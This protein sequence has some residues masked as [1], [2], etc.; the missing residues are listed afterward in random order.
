VDLF[1]GVEDFAFSKCVAFIGFGHAE[2]GPTLGDID[3]N[4]FLGSF[5]RAEFGGPIQE[6]EGAFFGGKVEVAKDH[7]LARDDDCFAITWGEDVVG[8]KHELDGF[9]L[10]CFAKWDVDRHL[11]TV[12]VGV[13]A[14]ADKWMET[15]CAT[16]DELW[17]EGLDG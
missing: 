12:E 13:E 5:H 4:G 11:V 7:V 10:G 2:D 14:R 6:V 9:L 8:G 17:L 3:A 1:N 16:I 15:D